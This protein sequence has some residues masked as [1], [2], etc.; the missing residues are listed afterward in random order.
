MDNIQANTLR[1]S[2]LTEFIEAIKNLASQAQE[3]E[4]GDFTSISGNIHFGNH[5]FS[6][7]FN[8]H[9]IYLYL[10]PRDQTP[11]KHF[12]NFTF[13]SV[14]DNHSMVWKSNQHTFNSPGLAEFCIQQL[15]SAT[16]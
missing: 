3:L 5:S 11:K 8:T 14:E 7:V 2:L 10:Q 9:T 13:K 1:Q 15:K 4:L 12:P 16:R 6:F